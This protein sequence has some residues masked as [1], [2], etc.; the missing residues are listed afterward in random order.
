MQ[1][2]S[3]GNSDSN[4]YTKYHQIYQEYQHKL[5]NSN[6]K[7]DKQKANE[8]VLD[9]INQKISDIQQNL[10]IL[11]QYSASQKLRTTGKS[12]TSFTNN[13]GSEA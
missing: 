7:E 6:V 8:Q 2:N 11:S 1:L 4:P 9:Q 5:S 10:N 12:Q 13:K 3:K